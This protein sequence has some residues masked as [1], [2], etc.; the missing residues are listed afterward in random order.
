MDRKKR[1]QPDL[2]KGERINIILFE[3]YCF[4][5]SGK[6]ERQTQS[7]ICDHYGDSNANQI[8][9]FSIS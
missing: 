8:A 9:H 1:N 3:F 7:K 2:V 5:G 4:C 6:K